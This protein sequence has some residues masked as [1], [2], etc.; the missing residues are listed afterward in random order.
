MRRGARRLLA[1]G[2]G[3]AAALVPAEL[4]ARACT[5]GLWLHRPPRLEL[6]F[7]PDPARMPGVAGES[8]YRTSSLGL[9]ADE[10]RDQARRVLAVGGSTT[11]C[12]YLDQREAWPQLVQAALGARDTWVGNAGGS[13][14]ALADHLLQVQR[15]GPQLGELDAVVVLVG[16]NDLAQALEHRGAVPEALDPRARAFHDWPREFAWWPPER[17]A[18]AQ[19]V[20]R[21][22]GR[23]WAAG[24]GE[25]AL[26]TNY[27]LR[28]AARASGAPYV[29]V[30]VEELRGALTQYRER[31]ALLVRRVRAL[32]AQP[33]LLTQPVLWRADLAA[34]DRALLWYGWRGRPPWEGPD[35]Y[36]SLATLERAM[37]AYNEVTRE[38]CGALDVALVDLARELPRSREVLYD[39]CHLN[40]AGARR[41][42]ELVAPALREL[43][44]S[45]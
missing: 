32:G 17:T 38:V 6:V 25:D 42:A 33:L 3:S 39:D 13:G 18:L 27:D 2:L 36:A 9:R 43:L 44:G 45:E 22:R 26:G 7:R 31:L 37:R 14:L 40:E 21:A 16:V 34:E 8:L 41:V 10:L 12:E 29:D 20:R 23:R 24:A 1:L 15:L 35:G 28:R 5:D 4:V 11:A 30:P 19:L